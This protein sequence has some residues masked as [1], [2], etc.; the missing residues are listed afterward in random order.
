MGL[1][2]WVGLVSRAQDAQIKW[3]T[4]ACEPRDAQVFL[5]VSGSRPYLL[6]PCNQPLPLDLGLF[7]GRRS[8]AITL[9]RPGWQDET[10]ILQQSPVEFGFFANRDRYPD[11]SQ[12]PV[13]LTPQADLA[14]RGQQAAYFVRTHWPGLA[15]LAGLGLGSLAWLRSRLQRAS[16]DRRRAQEL[17]QLQA[18]SADLLLGRKLGA[19]R[20]VSLLGAGGMGS[21]YRAE[22]DESVAIK[23]MRPE[24]TADPVARQR[25]RRE[26]EIY[27][28]LSHPN[29]VRLLDFGEQD[30]LL[31]L[32]LELLEGKTMRQV[33]AGRR[34]A[35]PE[36]LDYLRRLAPALDYAHAHSIVHRDLKP[37]NVFLTGSGRLV[38]M[39]FGVAGGGEYTRATLT[40]QGLGTPEYMAPEQ[41]HGRAEPASDRYSLGIMLYEMLEGRVPFQGEDSLAVAFMQVG[42]E[43]PP[44]SADLPP[45][46]AAVVRRLLAKNPRRRF[47]SC[48]E[49]VEALEAALK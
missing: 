48:A 5:E 27:R 20:L 41:V 38:V 1:V 2:L 9:R 21:V 28:D 6:G 26:I 17:E 45:G 40:G 34:L 24:F 19:Y 13:R 46:V 35:P 8:V 3:V 43:P 12:G 30:G 49:A 37:E 7:D 10:R 39:D 14:S 36:A 33:L 47:G 29:I 22:G 31:Y 25:F 42:Q 23:I 16:Q 44:L 32:V 18:T 11:P 4:F 15:V